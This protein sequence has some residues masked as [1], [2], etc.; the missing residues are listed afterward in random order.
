M[1]LKLGY[2]LPTRENIMQN[3]PTGHDIDQL[4]TTIYLTAVIM[5]DATAADTAINTYLQNYYNIPAA[6]MRRFRV[7]FGGPL[8]QVL[9]FIR[10]YIDAGVEH[11]VP[12]LVGDHENMFTE[13]PSFTSCVTPAFAIGA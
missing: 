9:T 1:T 6:V 8:E 11:V 3:R 12:R 7:C 10:S 13:A 4:T 2:L 5:D